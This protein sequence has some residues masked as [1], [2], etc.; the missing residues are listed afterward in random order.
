MKRF[1]IIAALIVLGVVQCASQEYTI[2]DLGTETTV[3]GIN[4]SGQIVGWIRNSD[5][6]TCSYRTAPNTPVN[7]STDD[8]GSF[9]SDDW[10]VVG[11]INDSGQVVGECTAAVNPL[12]YHAFRTAPNSLINQSSD[13]LGTLGGRLSFARA[14]NASGRATGSANNTGD[15]TV[16]AFR[17]APNA[18]IDPAADDLGT[19]GGILSVGYGI[20]R[21]G[22][23]AGYSFTPG[24]TSYH[25]F[26]TA[27]DKPIVAATDDLTP[28]GV[29]SRAASLAYG[30]NDS[31]EVVGEFYLPSMIGSHAFRT[32]PNRAI[33]PAKDDLGTLGGRSSSACCINASGQVV[34]WSADAYTEAQHAFL[35]S[36]GVMINLNTMAIPWGWE[37]IQATGINDSGQIVGI[38]LH[39]GKI[40]GFL[41]T[42]TNPYRARIQPPISSNEISVFKIQRKVV[43]VRFALTKG[44]EPTCELPAAKIS[45]VRTVGD[46]V[47]LLDEHTYASP[48]ESHA[49]FR[50]DPSACMYGYNL[51]TASLGAG[52]YRVQIS[53]AGHVVGTAM[54]T[55]K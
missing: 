27:P 11:G 39:N 22:Q 36:N 32:A 47:G 7:C 28:G 42:P 46:T 3:V 53:I 9:L 25:A 44:G 13:D 31:A 50:I 1:S 43:P 37:L 18:S 45:V 12:T 24:D 41:L 21:F 10:C 29:F 48:S 51:A 54:F 40:H 16:H 30:I 26:R 20:N 52:M 34:G 8:L 55:L 38:G 15:A 4:N 5:G 23:V 49:D 2:I 33:D 14:I 35:Y 6:S 17:T 19:L